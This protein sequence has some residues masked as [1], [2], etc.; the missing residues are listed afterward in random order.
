MRSSRSG[1]TSARRPKADADLADR[2]D[3]AEGLCE[4]PNAMGSHDA[5]SHLRPVAS[6]R[7]R[8]KGVPG[9]PNVAVT[10]GLSCNGYYREDAKTRRREDAKTRRREETA[11]RQRVTVPSVEYNPVNPANPVTVCSC[12]LQL[13][14]PSAIAERLACQALGRPIRSCRQSRTPVVRTI[15]GRYR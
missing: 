15:S 14:L 2:A 6:S 4:H 3:P 12:S 9:S 7:F 11:W 13:P 5:D 8:G 1:L 10:F